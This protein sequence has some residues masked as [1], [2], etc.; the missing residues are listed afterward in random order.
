MKRSE[1][2]EKFNKSSHQMGKHNEIKDAD[3]VK[4]QNGK[5]TFNES[6]MG[7]NKSVKIFELVDGSEWV[8]TE[9]KI[10]SKQK[11]N[12]ENA[13][14][15]YGKAVGKKIKEL[16][17]S[18]KGT[19]K[20]H[21]HKISVE[22]GVPKIVKKTKAEM[23]ANE[24]T[25]KK[26][27]GK[28]GKK[29]SAE[30]IKK[31]QKTK[32]KNESISS[33]RGDTELIQVEVKL[34]LEGNFDGGY[35][36]ATLL[37]NYGED[38]FIESA[39]VDEEEGTLDMII[40]YSVDGEFTSFKTVYDNVEEFVK[41]AVEEFGYTFDISDLAI[42]K[43][44]LKNAQKYSR[45]DE[46]VLYDKRAKP[47]SISEFVEMIKIIEENDIDDAEFELVSNGYGKFFSS[48][49][50]VSEFVKLINF[51]KITLIAQGE[52]GESMFT[53]NFRN[54]KFITPVVDDE[55]NMFVFGSSVQLEN[56]FSF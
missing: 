6:S 15:K 22:D 55:L 16:K 35:E 51:A 47:F 54:Y 40:E 42:D 8:C 20:E 44:D 32:K 11:F 49:V 34:D 46:S 50:S 13:T 17:A 2:I 30:A 23:K 33:L 7:I 41:E 24:K 53:K 29:P 12:E 31:G 43:K 18:L 10:Y 45:K 1:F 19:P 26:M 5:I 37:V 52:H 9:D 25:S 27:S 21:T 4:L 39:Y 3:I 28:K 14:E 38:I 56:D 48:P 36:L